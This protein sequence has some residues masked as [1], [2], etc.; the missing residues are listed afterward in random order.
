MEL[1]YGRLSTPVNLDDKYKKI[2]EAFVEEKKTFMA[3]AW[4][5][6][7]KEDALEWL[8]KNYPHEKEEQTL[9]A[10]I[11][12]SNIT[13]IDDKNARSKAL[14]DTIV[15]IKRHH[16]DE[17]SRNIQD[18]GELQKIIRLKSELQHLHISL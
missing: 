10:A 6:E 14:T 16:L 2:Y 4:I 5:V 15:R 8:L 3:K 12:N 11:F 13:G 1:V 17:K 7:K 9:V 18:L